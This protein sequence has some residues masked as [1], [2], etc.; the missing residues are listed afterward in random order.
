[1][2]RIKRSVTAQYAASYL[3]VGFVAGGELQPKQED[4]TMKQLEE[5][6]YF[7]CCC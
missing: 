5:V 4:D 7:R 1:M 3:S 6:N 2:F